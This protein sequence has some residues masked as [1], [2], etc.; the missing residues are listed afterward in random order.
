M[1]I[2]MKIISWNSGAPEY[3]IIQDKREDS[4]DKNRDVLLTETATQRKKR[5]SQVSQR[6][7]CTR[8]NEDPQKRAKMIRNRSNVEIGYLHVQER[9]P[10][11]KANIPITFDQ[12]EELKFIWIVWHKY[13]SMTKCYLVKYMQCEITDLVVYDQIF[14]KN[15]RMIAVARNLGIDGLPK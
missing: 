4:Q 5:L 15:Y 12:L 10:I 1:K 14:L 7:Q 3:A 9:E 2:P 8:E 11:M 13:V 6:T